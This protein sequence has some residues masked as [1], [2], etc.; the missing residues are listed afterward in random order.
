MTRTIIDVLRETAA[1]K[2]FGPQTFGQARVS[3]K[4]AADLLERIL[5]AYD[6]YRGKGG[7]P[8]PN[9]YQNVV[10]AINAIRRPAFPQERSA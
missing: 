8:A 5:N 6:T 2:P 7:T 10:N 4:E 9:E 3:M 1:I